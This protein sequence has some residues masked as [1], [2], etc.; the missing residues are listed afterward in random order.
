[1]EW[2]HPGPRRA[3]ETL[4]RQL[5]LAQQLLHELG[6]ARRLAGVAVVEEQIR[7]PRLLGK[8]LDLPQPLPELALAVV[9]IVA[10]GAGSR[11]GS[12]AGG[13]E[14]G[15]LRR[16]RS[17]LRH[18]DRGARATL[19]AIAAPPVAGVAAVEAHV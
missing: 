8:L 18:R 4:S 19:G 2:P 11:R 5:L 9:V 16:R 6:V 1:M 7:A 17:R 13:L 12:G 14:Q 10:V 3:R 15:A